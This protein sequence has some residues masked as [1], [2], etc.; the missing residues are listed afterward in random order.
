[1]YSS[2]TMS[3]AYSCDTTK[4]LLVGHTCSCS[5]PAVECQARN[6]TDLTQLDLPDLTEVLDL[7]RN[8]LQYLGDSS[9]SWQAPIRELFLSHNKIRNISSLAFSNILGVQVIDLSHNQIY[10]LQSGLFHPLS[11]LETLSL[12]NNH[13]AQLPH[14]L[15]LPHNLLA[16]LDLSRNPLHDLSPGPLS[17]LSYRS[18]LM[19]LHSCVVILLYHP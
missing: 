3:A 10:S 2:H 14:D 8:M 12:S 1:M 19:V 6:L 17:H 7:S 4:H 11:H 15:F 16:S 5:Y 13:L 18:L 9:L